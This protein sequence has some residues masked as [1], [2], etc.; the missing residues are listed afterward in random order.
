MPLNLNQSGPESAAPPAPAFLFAPAVRIFWEGRWEGTYVE[1]WRRLYDCEL[2][3]VSAGAFDLYLG[4]QAHRL[5]AGAL[6]LIPP[7]LRHESVLPAGGRV[8]R[9]CIHFDWLPPPG[10]EPRPLAAFDHE[11][12][13]T[14][15]RTVMPPPEIAGLLPLVTT[16]DAL[17]PEIKS[18]LAAMLTCL[19]S[20]AYGTAGGLLWPVLNA[21]LQDAAR[22]A[23]P[24]APHLPPAAGKTWR[25]VLTAKDH[26]ER[27][28]ATPVTLGQLARRTRLTPNH[29]CRAFRR[30]LGKAP[31]QYLNDLR[32]QHAC[33]LLQA[34]QLN[35]AETAAAVGIP[36]ANYFARLFRQKTGF[37]PS[38]YP[39]THSL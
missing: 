28:Y 4:E 33:R 34:G 24:P 35:I 32:M 19:R 12:F 20:G 1:P 6:I 26:L 11:R 14:L 5:T 9:H 7:R 30:V 13:E 36:D 17:A 15:G 8:M 27:F 22:H 2:V 37:R 31:V 29:L 25:A 16:L 10:R 21:L 3:Y 23:F 18:V 39:Q 38:E